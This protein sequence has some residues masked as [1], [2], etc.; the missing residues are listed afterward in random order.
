MSM[1]P[2]TPVWN[3]STKWRSSALR[4]SAAAAAAAACSSRMRWRSS[5]LFLNTATV[6]AISPISSWRSSQS[7]A[8][9]LLPSAIAVSEAVTEVK[10]LG[11]AADD[12]HGEQ[13]HQ[14]RGDAGRDRH[15]LDRLRQHGLELR[16]GDADIENADHLSGRI[17]DR[18]SRPS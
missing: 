18:D 1:M 6:R 15:G 17:H 12:Q 16:H 5:E 2:P 14:Q 11:D 4:C 8:T 10:R 3:S 13:H 9:S 7:I